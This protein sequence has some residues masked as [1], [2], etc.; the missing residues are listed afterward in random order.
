[1]SKRRCS[2][3]RCSFVPCAQV[4]NQRYCSAP[5]CQ[6]ARKRDWQRNKRQTDPDYQE[7][8]RQAQQRWANQNPDYWKNYRHQHPSAVE[9]NRTQQ[10]DRDRRRREASSQAAPTSIES[11]LPPPGEALAKM[12]A[13]IPKTSLTS[14]TYELLPVP[15][16]QA[17]KDGRVNLVNLYIINR[18]T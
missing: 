1:M 17:C 2:N 3:C 4:R 7:N 14:G 10:R 8:Q 15:P 16:Q 11:L 18:L 5:D 6:R 12:D 13:W 9:R